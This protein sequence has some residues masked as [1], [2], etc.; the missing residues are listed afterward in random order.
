M[1]RIAFENYAARAQQNISYTE[2]AGRH[3]IQAEQEANV[4]AD[5]AR[6]LELC[7]DDSLLEIGCGTGNLL[8]PL[9]RLVK[10]ATGLDHAAILDVLRSRLREETNIALI[11]GNFLDVAVNGEFSKVLIYSVLHL[12]TDHAEVLEIIRRAVGLL[13]PGGMLLLG[14]IPNQDKRSRF[15]AT[16]RGKR[17]E[18]E[19]N[20]RVEEQASKPVELPALRALPQ[21]DKLVIFDDASIL[22]ILQNARQSGFEAYV[23]RQSE[24][25]PVCFSRED[26]LVHRLAQ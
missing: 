25:L 5:V 3:S 4:P 15:L 6:K 9:S 26:I 16:E 12:L 20:R 14:D 8:L 24:D 22:Q 1:S 23:L 11:P 13:T 7:G 10:S 17:F 21:D 19:W 18:S 2:M